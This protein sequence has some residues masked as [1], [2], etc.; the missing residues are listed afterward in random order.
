MNKGE[1]YIAILC[2]NAVAPDQIQEVCAG[3]EEEGVAFLLQK[4]NNVKNVIQL[5]SEAASISPL[6]VGIGVDKNGDLCVHHQK[7]KQAEP[8]LQDNLQ[9]ARQLGKN[10]ARLVKG[11]PLSF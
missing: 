3:L 11:L 7:L 10:A 1:I 2:N 4:R 5:G 6:Q 9:N 8:Y